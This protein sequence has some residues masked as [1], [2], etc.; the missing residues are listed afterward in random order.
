MNE[1]PLLDKAPST[2]TPPRFFFKEWNIL[3]DTFRSRAAFL[4]SRSHA[5]DLEINRIEPQSR[6]VDQ[7]RS[8]IAL[9][10]EIIN[11]RDILK[12]EIAL[13]GKKVEKRLGGLDVEA[14]WRR[15]HE[16][17]L[18]QRIDGLKDMLQFYEGEELQRLQLEVEIKMRM[19][20]VSDVVVSTPPILSSRPSDCTPDSPLILSK[21]QPTKEIKP[22]VTLSDPTQ[23]AKKNH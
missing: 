12:E 20:E 9:M 22:Q 4:I 16:K 1:T 17:A 21:P 8:W 14:G 10:N 15:E 18:S 2:E 13:C 19:N 7:L 23:R 11:E 6:T 3:F 5:L